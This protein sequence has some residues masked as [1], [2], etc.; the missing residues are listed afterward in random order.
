ME[1]NLD[2]AI[3]LNFVCPSDT[4]FTIAVLSVNRQKKRVSLKVRL[5]TLSY[6]I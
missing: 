4:A 1:T 3:A 2:M 5:R 6:S